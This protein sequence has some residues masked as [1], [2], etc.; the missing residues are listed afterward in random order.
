[1]EMKRLLALVVGVLL[2]SQVVVGAAGLELLSLERG[3]PEGY[4]YFPAISSDSRWASFTT[5]GSLIP[6]DHNNSYDIYVRNLV[7]G[8]LERI[9]LASDGS[10][11]NGPSHFSLLSADGRFVAFDSYASNLVPG[12]VNNMPDVFLRDRLNGTTEL[13]S[14]ASDG[15]P[16][17]QPSNGAVI[18]ADGR[19]VAF[20]ST[21]SNLAP[22]YNGSSIAVYLRD[23]VLQTTTRIAPYGSDPAM[24]ADGRFV[25]YRRAKLE[26]L[27][28]QTGLV[29]VVGPF[30]FFP[31]QPSISA[32]GRYVAY[33]GLPAGGTPMSIAV[34]V[35][36]RLTR[37]Q[38][39]ITPTIDRSPWG[40]TTVFSSWMSLR[41]KISA[42]GRFVL[43]FCASEMTPD[44]LG[45]QLNL[46][47][48][49]TERTVRLPI[50]NLWATYL[51]PYFDLSGD[52]SVVVF[53]DVIQ[54]LMPTYSGYNPNVLGIFAWRTGVAGGADPAGPAGNLTLT[55]EPSLLWPA[56]SKLT[57]V[58]LSTVA[59]KGATVEIRIAD[60]YGTF[61]QTLFGAE[62]T[63]PLEAWRQGSDKDGRTYTI[64]AVATDL[65]GRQETATTI[66]SVPHDQH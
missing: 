15:T 24:S 29:E 65:A 47:D 7:T 57:S 2:C 61:S 54:N 41:P 44:H 32:D 28:R 12:D 34:F 14:V 31:A 35:Y 3:Q 45:N 52:G 17:N 19:Y 36:D 56:N 27:D 64:T 37:T 58:K 49:T 43:S 1:M 62:V 40:S 25:A 8:A 16:G 50:A 9:S 26:V 55:A 23:R 22:N 48:L 60:E 13:I 11:A 21:A 10:E 39:Q 66:V 63:V 18:S 4:S 59:S 6:Q 5:F 20:H 51:Y 38:R 53:H 46:Y 30:A 42:D 33:E